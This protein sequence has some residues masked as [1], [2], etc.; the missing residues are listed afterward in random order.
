V[1]T[2]SCSLRLIKTISLLHSENSPQPKPQ[3]SEECSRKGF[4]RNS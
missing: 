2:I 3:L 4:C 1:S